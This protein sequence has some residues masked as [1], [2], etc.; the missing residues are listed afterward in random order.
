MGSLWQIMDRR[1]A[2]VDSHATNKGEHMGTLRILT[3]DV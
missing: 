1:I 2:L 3:W